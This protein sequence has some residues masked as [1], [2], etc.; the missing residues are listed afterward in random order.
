M[1]T[2][3]IASFMRVIVCTVATGS[4]SLC[5]TGCADP[6]GP[7]SSVRFR[8]S[9]YEVRLAEADVHK[10]EMTADMRA[11]LQARLQAL[12]STKVLYKVDEVI[13]LA[14]EARMTVSARVPFVTGVR[15]SESGKEIRS[16][17]YQPVGAVYKVS[18]EP[19][20]GSRGK[21]LDVRL[22]VELSAV[23]ESQ[24]KVAAGVAAVTL[25]QAK[26]GHSGRVKLGRPIV[27][28]TVD[29]SAKDKDGLAVAYVCRA[30]FSRPQ[31]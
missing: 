24:T 22:K 28:L 8:A 21:L 13:D 6:A 27:M 3:V 9:I 31:D 17:Q 26:L 11:N 2:P 7:P 18:G 19:V 1:K 29:T 23:T 25:R 15:M 30:E 5:L 16:V 10:L 14:D 12:G 4:L 20:S